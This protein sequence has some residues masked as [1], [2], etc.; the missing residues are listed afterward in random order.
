VDENN[1]QLLEKVEC[2]TI[3]NLQ[4][5]WFG[6]ITL[7]SL[8]LS[9]YLWFQVEIDKFILFNL[10]YTNFSH[11]MIQLNQMAS[12]F[13]MSIIVFIYLVYLVLALIHPKMS[14][15]RQVYLLIIFSFAIAGISGDILKEL[16]N[17]TRPVFEYANELQGLTKSESPSFPSG[18]ATKSI[19]LVLPYLFFS[20]FKGWLHTLVKFVLMFI[21][22]AVC[23][24]RIFLGAHY[25]SDVLAG[26]AWAS[27]ILPL[28]VWASNFILNKMTKNDLEKAVKKWL[29]V[30]VALIIILALI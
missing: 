25:L 13:G 6:I 9:F 29:F 17:R 18:H 1:Q 2:F 19:A 20:S 30:Y 10:N 14:E 4:W 27:L 16:F 28:A 23:F 12:R 7:V 22:L 21:A 8:S 15:G 26:L 5:F 11:V 3:S 24:S